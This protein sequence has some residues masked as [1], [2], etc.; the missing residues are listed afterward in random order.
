MYCIV[1]A[2]LFFALNLLNDVAFNLQPA[3]HYNVM[4]SFCSGF[5]CNLKVNNETVTSMENKK[6]REN[7]GL[8][9]N[10]LLKCNRHLYKYITVLL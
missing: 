3:S 6:I 2:Y 5:T 9:L 1:Y 10:W 8:H 7:F 4:C